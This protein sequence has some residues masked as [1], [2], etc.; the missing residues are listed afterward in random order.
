MRVLPTL[1][2]YKEQNGAYPKGL[3][4]SLATLIYFYKNDNPDDA[5]FV[6]AT[7]KN[8][9]IAEILANTSLWQTDLSDM[10]EIVTVCY[11]KI[12]TLGAKEVMKWILS[13]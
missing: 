3:T 12:D 2:E 9:S 6:V 7:M 10:T 11:N 1:L 8:D 4:L 5:E 13:E